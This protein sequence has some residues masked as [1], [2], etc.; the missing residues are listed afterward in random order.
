MIE[1]RFHGR[2]GQGVVLA[3]E[4]LAHA[5]FL[6][7]KEVQA[8]PSFGA[9]QR[10]APVVAF[11]RSDDHSIRKRTQI[12]EPDHV[13]VMSSVLLNM[14]VD[15]CEGLKKQGT[16]VLNFARDNQSLGRYRDYK[17]YVVDANPIAMKHGLGTSTVP[18]VNC[19]M[20][21]AFVGATSL[22]T[23]E[24]LAEAIS[25]RLLTQSE[26]NILAAREAAEAVHPLNW[27]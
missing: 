11:V 19:V 12:R 20:L 1:V 3:S 9:E 8:F 10:G 17:V 21:G 6:E 22:V 27:E 4:I 13:V 14:G 23:I 18:I 2:G 16:L 25:L 5:L 26:K 24:S 15:F 7:G